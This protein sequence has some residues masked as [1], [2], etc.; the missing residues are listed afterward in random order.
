MKNNFGLIWEKNRWS[1]NNFGAR[2]KRTSGS[3]S[4]K[5]WLVSVQHMEGQIISTWFH[6]LCDEGF[7][8]KSIVQ[9]IVVILVNKE[10]WVMAPPGGSCRVTKE[11]KTWLPSRNAQCCEKGVK[12]ITSLLNWT[13]SESNWYSLTQKIKDKFACGYLDSVFVFTNRT[14]RLVLCLK[15]L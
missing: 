11:A 9:K 2:R 8:F 7:A 3:C 6:H 15:L 10:N 14:C 1:S 4:K 5:H 12:S 13:D